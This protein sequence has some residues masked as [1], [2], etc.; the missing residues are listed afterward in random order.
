MRIL[1][2]DDD[3]T[4]RRVLQ[5][6]LEKG[7]Y[8]VLVSKDGLEAWDAMSVP[9]SPQLAI[10]DWRMPGMDGLE[11][12][13]RLRQSHFPKEPYL[14]MLT[15]L[16]EKKHVIEALDSGADDYIIKPFD[17]MELLARVSV[18][19]RITEIQNR[20]VDQAEELSRALDQ[21]K[22]LT[23]LIPICCFCKRI[24]D[25]S[26]YWREVEDYVTANT[27]ALFSH[28][29]CPDCAKKHYPDDF[30]DE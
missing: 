16:G 13:Q 21:V 4:S 9:D 20:L 27:D 24:R 12:C 25:D 10:L 17:P 5:A 8:E 19:R 23:G 28:S 2:A 3:Y 7:G 26:D 14:I 29:L 6:I 11:L 22:T 1:I 15:S 18:G 30:D